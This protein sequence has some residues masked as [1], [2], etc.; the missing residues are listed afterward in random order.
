MTDLGFRHCDD[1]LDNP[2]GVDP[3][4]LAWLTYRRSPASVKYPMHG[5]PLP[6]PLL[7][8]TYDHRP[9]RMTLAS[10]LGDIGI[11][12]KLWASDS[13]ELRVPLAELSDFRSKP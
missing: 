3:L 1:W 10:R 4:L 6:E 8:A 2:E 11:S 9:V 7:F 5:E 13:Y 12:R